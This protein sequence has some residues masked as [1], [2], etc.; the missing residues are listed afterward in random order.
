[1]LQCSRNN[2][3]T[4][5]LSSLRCINDFNDSLVVNILHIWITV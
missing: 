2:N 3:V 5:E 1:M 4:F